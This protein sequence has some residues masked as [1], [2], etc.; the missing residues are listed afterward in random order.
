VVIDPGEAPV[1]V[2]ELLTEEKYRALMQEFPGR[3]K[4]MMG[5][6]AIK[7]LL[8]QVNVEEL[9]DELRAAM[10]PRPPSSRR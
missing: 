10:K 7:E 2:K 9:A 8:K 4:A 3:F 5:A 1:K 6:E